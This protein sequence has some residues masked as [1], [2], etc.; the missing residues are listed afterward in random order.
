MKSNPL[1]IY[2]L[3]ENFSNGPCDLCTWFLHLTKNYGVLILFVPLLVS[4]NF[5]NKILVKR[6]TTF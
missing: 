6:N 5:V 1:H 2:E 3:L 4:N